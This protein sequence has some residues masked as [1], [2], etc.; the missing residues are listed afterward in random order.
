MPQVRAVTLIKG[1]VQGVWFRAST[2]KE[3]DR[4]G[5]DG[6]VRNLP[7]RKVEAVF[8]GQREVVEQALAWCRLGPPRAEVREVEVS[9]HDPDPGLQGFEVRY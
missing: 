8:Q 4:L 3:A 6:Y 1:R 2:K 9:W 7:L 5:L